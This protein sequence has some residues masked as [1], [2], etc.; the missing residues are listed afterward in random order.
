MANVKHHAGNGGIYGY[1]S[2][3]NRYDLISVNANRAVYQYDAGSAGP[4][5][6]SVDPWRIVVNLSGVQNYRL[7]TGPDAG[8][9]VPVAGTI[10]ALSALGQG[11][12]TL[13]S[14]ISINLDWPL[15][16]HTE[17]VNS[18]SLWELMMGSRSTFYG[19]NDSDAADGW[20]GDDIATGQGNDRVFALGGDDFIGDRGGADTYNGGAGVDT[21]SYQEFAYNPV[22]GLRGVNANLGAGISY[23]PDGRPDRLISIEGIRGTLAADR[24]IGDGKDNSF[25]GLG[26]ADYF[27]GG[28]GFDQV[29]YD[30]DE[31]LGGT[32]GIKANL[33]KGW[34]RD[35]FGSVDT[36]LNIERI[37][38]T[39]YKDDILD[40]GRSNS[41][42]G[43]DGNDLLKIQRGDD[44][45]EGGDGA[46][47][48]I[49]WT[50][51]SGNN[52]IRDFDG[53]GGDRM[54]IHGVKSMSDV[55]LAQN[56]ND[57]VVTHS[58]GT[59]RLENTLLA[60]ID[61]NDFIF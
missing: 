1:A 50:P 24:V 54:R 35:G 22:G 33:M 5:D 27:N 30:R 53:D 14:A 56:G 39:D 7:T 16:F 20:D 41:F 19:S 44:W 45:M 55:S 42:S 8:S 32:S 17:H 31:N 38:G 51:Q 10:T 21:V 28:A 59:I 60:S 11:G 3:F 34:I 18:G 29:R 15:F 2:N 58:G 9:F 36:V 26:G 48:F 57:V 6:S 4:F 23:G 43:R 25:L 47:W 61:A 13:V 40:N 49:F 12:K 46:D 37:R 52:I